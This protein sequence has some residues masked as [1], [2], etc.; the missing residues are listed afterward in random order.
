MESYQVKGISLLLV[1]ALIAV[2]NVVAGAPQGKSEQTLCGAQ[3]QIVFSCITR[4]K[5]M[6]SLCASGKLKQS[7]DRVQYRFGKPGKIELSY[8]EKSE[9]WKDQF[10]FSTR[11]FSGGGEYHI[12]FVNGGVEYLLYDIEAHPPR[13]GLL[14]RSDGKAISRVKCLDGENSFISHQAFESMKREPYGEDAD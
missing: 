10:A 1:I 7:V 13:A 3:E 6:L 8:P 11:M 14:V 5:K 2:P 12:R 4:Q 9:G